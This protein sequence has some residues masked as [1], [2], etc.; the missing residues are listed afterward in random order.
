MADEQRRLGALLIGMGLLDEGQLERAL[1]EQR[2]SGRRLGRVLVDLGLL[3]E[4]ALADALGRQLGLERWS[5]ERF[6]SEPAARALVTPNAALRARLLPLARTWSD[7][8]ETVVIATS[9]PLAPLAARVVRSLAER[10]ALVRWML[11]EETQLD[12]ALA[13]TYGRSARGGAKVEAMPIIQGLPEA[14]AT[15]STLM[16]DDAVL[17]IIEIDAGEPI[18]VYEAPSLGILED[19]SAA[20]RPPGESQAGDPASAASGESATVGSRAPSPSGT[21]E[22]PSSGS[23]LGRDGWARAA[24]TG[25]TNWGELVPSEPPAERGPDAGSGVALARVAIRKSRAGLREVIPLGARRADQRHERLASPGEGDD[26]DIDFDV[27]TP[28]PHPNPRSEA[29]GD[30]ARSPSPYVEDGAAHASAR[31]RGPPSEDRVAPSLAATQVEQIEE[32][33]LPAA[34]SAS[35]EPSTEDVFASEP[36][37][38]PADDLLELIDDTR[39]PDPSKRD[40]KRGEV[41]QAPSPKES[42]YP[43]DPVTDRASPSPKVHEAS[44]G[45]RSSPSRD[46]QASAEPAPGKDPVD[47]PRTYGPE[48]RTTVGEVSFSW[49]AEP[50]RR[51]VDGHEGRPIPGDEKTASRRVTPKSG[52]E[53]PVV[54]QFARSIDSDLQDGE[55]AESG[56][57]ARQA[58]PS[59]PSSSPALRAAEGSGATEGSTASGPSGGRPYGVPTAPTSSEA[60]ASRPKVPIEDRAT[61]LYARL[62]RFAAGEGLPAAIREDAL[63]VVIALLIEQRL[64]DEAAVERALARYS[65]SGS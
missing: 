39:S 5:P 3:G 49:A 27:L 1:E 15:G 43:D 9:D 63:R 19:S 52:G 21:G 42:I 51:G 2:S 44:G 24:R 38:G 29:P 33:G 26:R 57:R 40:A 53:S 4:R 10:G 65:S 23:S 28:V 32:V 59:P 7:G 61:E 45:A 25:E 18:R 31:L 30:V 62:V 11:A 56:S 36:T 48:A 14:L 17:E 22:D 12:A 41:A 58:S 46:A 13:A 8:R 37:V 16:A 54:E 34:P 55:P 50:P 20:A 64:L 47:R 60:F 6:P 35:L